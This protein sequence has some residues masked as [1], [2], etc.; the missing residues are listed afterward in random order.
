VGDCLDSRVSENGTVSLDISNGFRDFAFSRCRD[1]FAP[2]RLG[3]KAVF[4]TMAT[5][6]GGWAYAF[7]SVLNEE[8][9]IC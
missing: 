8:L 2:S 6:P 4:W 5:S 3:V 9:Q 7:Q 1:S